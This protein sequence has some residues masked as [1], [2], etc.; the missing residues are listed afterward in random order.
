M[1][2]DSNNTPGDDR[3]WLN[4]AAETIYGSPQ[5]RE[6]SV[7]GLTSLI[8]WTF[9]LFAA[10][11]GGFLSIFGGIRD[12][13]FNTLIAF[14]FAFFFLCLAY[15]LANRALYPVAKSLI[16]ADVSSIKTAFSETTTKQTVRFQWASCFTAIGF[17]CLAAGIFFQFW[18]LSK[19]IHPKLSPEYYMNTKV[20]R[21]G[22]SIFIPVTIV[23]NK[24]HAVELSIINNSNLDS[25]SNNKK[26][27]FKRVF[28]TDTAGRL[29]YS[30]HLSCDTLKNVIESGV[31]PKNY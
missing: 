7:K 14:S 27:L 4:L 11:T 24:T 15:Y 29:Y 22:D 2:I 31:P 12:F 26:I 6:D 25:I 16:P 3:F 8:V 9:G 5:K 1:P 28:L 23:N 13:S 21:R 17:F 19:P 18:S 20:E 10:G 30:Y